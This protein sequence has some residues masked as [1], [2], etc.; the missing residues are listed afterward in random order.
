MFGRHSRRQT[1]V[2]EALSTEV[3]ISIFF[4]TSSSYSAPHILMLP[5]PLPILSR[6]FQERF[7]SVQWI[8]SF[9]VEDGRHRFNWHR[10]YR[11][12]ITGDREERCFGDPK[13]E[14]PA[15]TRTPSSP[16]EI[17]TL[18]SNLLLR[19]FLHRVGA[20]HVRKCRK[21]FVSTACVWLSYSIYMPFCFVH[22][23]LAFSVS[24]NLPRVTLLGKKNL[25]IDFLFKKS[26]RTQSVMN[27]RCWAKMRMCDW[28][29]GVLWEPW[30][31]AA[32]QQVSRM[33]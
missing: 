16:S 19:L 18:K 6:S 15:T 2:T 26:V 30:T 4:E 8:H 12:R 21:S 24:T 32:G 33:C 13:H 20:S 22:V 11:R 10:W 29:T 27:A 7:S 1:Q 28:F 17:R 25:S 31:P 3:N 23:N 14:K 5:S 9:F